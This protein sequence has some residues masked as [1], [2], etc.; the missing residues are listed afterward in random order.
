MPINCSGEQLIELP[1][2]IADN[3]G[4]P[5]KGQKSYTTKFLEARY[6]NT[7]AFSTRLSFI[8]E[9][10][11]LEGMFLINTTPLGSHNTMSDYGR[12]LFSRFILTQFRR[13]CSE[14]HV[15]F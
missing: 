9:C 8:P 2:A 7:T 14:V 5:I 11:L 10:V 12:F 4:N 3:M 1:L 6:K 15:I 13:G